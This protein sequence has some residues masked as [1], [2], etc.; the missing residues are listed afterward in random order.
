[1][2]VDQIREVSFRVRVIFIPATNVIKLFE[3]SKNY[4]IELIQE[5]PIFVIYSRQAFDRICPDRG[6]R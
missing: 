6:M 1:M 5:G 4:E 3:N 2:E